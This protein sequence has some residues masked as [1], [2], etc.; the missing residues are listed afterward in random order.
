MTITQFIP[1]VGQSALLLGAVSCLVGVVT[2]GLGLWKKNY[3]F[4][5][6]GRSYAWLILLASAIASVVLEFALITHDFQLSFVAHNNSFQT[7]I[8]YCIT[9]MWSALQGSILLWSLILSLYLALMVHHFKSRAQDPLVGWATLTMYVVSGFF[10]VLMLVAS[11]PF[12]LIKGPIPFDGSGP[13]PLLQNNI[14]VAFHPPMLYLGF[15][16]FTVPFSFAIASLITGRQGEGWLVEVRRWT[17]FAWAFLTAGIILGGWWSY[18]VLGWGGFWAWDPVENASFLPWLTG[19][20][21]LHSVMVQE[22]RGMLRVWNLSLLLATFDLTILGTFLTRSGVVESVHSFSKSNIGP[23]ILG[24]F[25]F[26]VIVSLGLI[27]WRADL[28]KTGGGLDSPISKEGAFLANNLAFSGFAFVVLLGTVFPLVFQAIK[29]EQITVGRPYFDTMTAPIGIALLFLMA[30]GPALPWRKAS[31][32]L[33]LKRLQIPAWIGAITIL[34]CVLFG[35]RGFETVI[36]FGLAAFAGTSAMRQLILNIKRKGIAGL[37]GRSGGGMIVHIGLILVAVGLAASLSYGHRRQIQLNQGA[38]VTYHGYKLT[39][40]GMQI[41]SYPNRVSSVAKVRLGHQTVYPGINQFSSTTEG[42]G[43]PV[44]MSSFANDVYLTLDAAPNHF[45]GPAQIGVIIQPLVSWL[46]TGGAIMFVGVLMAAIPRD[47]KD[48]TNVN[49]A[50]NSQSEPKPSAKTS[51][52]LK[53][54]HIQ[55]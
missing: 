47:K 10:F 54:A 39:Y 35:L 1:V 17:L 25:A 18:Q 42:I 14:L 15:V 7:P 44:V 46:W 53:M 41:H 40:L 52:A 29:N 4:L 36:T 8:L 13:N 30:V 3:S 37:F 6:S 2:L 31:G 34:V 43:T 50:P 49:I 38:S 12:S 45:G 16:G 32:S 23:D 21:Y 9:G 20:A 19:T 48:S 11:N 28:L 55:K 33:M 5:K 22:R 26:V 27:A 51:L 24:F